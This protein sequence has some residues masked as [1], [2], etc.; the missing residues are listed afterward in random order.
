M[1]NHDP[2]D[3]HVACYQSP[4]GPGWIV[5][6]GD[7]ITEVLLP[8]TGQPAPLTAHPPA[9]VASLAGELSEYFAG[10]PWPQH[11]EL[12]ARAGSTQFTRSVY[13][14]VAAIP[15]GLVRTYGDIARQLGRPGAA[16]AVGRAM[17]TNPFPVVIPCHRVVGSNGSLTGFGGGLDMKATMLR[18]EGAP[19]G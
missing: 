12:V 18:M 14:L 13:D 5:Y 19:R 7:E 9:A 17:A 16:R 11:P 4:F 2:V 15:A 3:D 8:G 6:Q 1:T 10:G